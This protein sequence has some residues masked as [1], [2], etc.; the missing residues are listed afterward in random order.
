LWFNEL[1]RRCPL[2][3]VLSTSDVVKI[4]LPLVNGKLIFG[5][6]FDS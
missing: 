5:V 1:Q 4:A 3:S 6:S 2:L